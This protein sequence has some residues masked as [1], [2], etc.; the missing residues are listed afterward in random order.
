[1][2]NVRHW[3]E[4]EGM[5]VAVD[6]ESEEKVGGPDGASPGF[7]ADLDDSLWARPLGQERIQGQVKGGLSEPTDAPEGLQARVEVASLLGLGGH[8]PADTPDR[9]PRDPHQRT[10]RFLDVLT[11]N[12]AT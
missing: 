8:S 4:V 12:H 10:D 1:V 6:S 7:R 3:E 5:D 2:V 11:A 9:P